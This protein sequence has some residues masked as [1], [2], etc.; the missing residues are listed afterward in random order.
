MVIEKL[1]RERG[2][3]KL[4]SADITFHSFKEVLDHCLEYAI[5]NKPLKDDIIL[6]FL[7]V[8]SEETFCV[9]IGCDE[10][11]TAYARLHSVIHIE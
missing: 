7:I 10:Y 9:S 3:R 11:G 1:V 8:D 6:E 2:S 5:N 4:V